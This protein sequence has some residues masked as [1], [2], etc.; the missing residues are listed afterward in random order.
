MRSMLLASKGAAH[1]TVLCSYGRSQQ[2]WVNL[3]HASPPWLPDTR[4]DASDLLLLPGSL[5]V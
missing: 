1:H 4:P 5:S 2:H 3:A